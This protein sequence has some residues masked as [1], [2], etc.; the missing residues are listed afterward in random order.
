M[1]EAEVRRHGN[2]LRPYTKLPDID[3][4]SATVLVMNYGLFAGR[5]ILYEEAIF[6]AP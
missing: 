2:V 4:D 3:S 1:V 5:P 6:T